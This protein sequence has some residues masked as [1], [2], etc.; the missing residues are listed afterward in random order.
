MEFITIIYYT[1]EGKHLM[2]PFTTVVDQSLN[3]HK[4][5]IEAS[6]IGEKLMS[7]HVPKN[8]KQAHYRTFEV[9]EVSFDLR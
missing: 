3:T 1:L 5:C 6:E 8:A 7:T 4:Q 9:G 2:I